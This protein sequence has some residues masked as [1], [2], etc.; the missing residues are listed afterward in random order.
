VDNVGEASK[1]ITKVATNWTSTLHTVNSATVAF[2][3][4]MQV[5]LTNFG[6]LWTTPSTAS[7]RAPT[8]G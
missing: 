6:T 5:S 7:T 8:H 3:S 4:A 2:F 1:A